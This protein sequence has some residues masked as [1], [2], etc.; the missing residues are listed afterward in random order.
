MS[1]RKI[2]D[3]TSEMQKKYAAFRVGM[4]AAGL[5][6]IITCTARTVKEQIALYAQGREPLETTNE[7]R[8]IAGLPK[9][10]QSQNRRKITWTLNSRHLIDL[11]D[12]NAANDK[13]RAFDIA[14]TR[15]SR[16]PHWDLKANVNANEKTDYEEA[17]LIGESVG[18]RWGGRFSSP[19]CVHFEL[20]EPDTQ[21]GG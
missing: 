1:S 6:F 5:D 16:N 10:A 11:D 19:D 13:A 15:G 18:L 20:S 4:T 17:G 21:K 9:I 7:L 3:L 8:K 14:L 2:S 12:G